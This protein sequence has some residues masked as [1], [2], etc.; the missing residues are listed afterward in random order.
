MQLPENSFRC[1]FLTFTSKTPPDPSGFSAVKSVFTFSS[2]FDIILSCINR[3]KEL[4]TLSTDFSTQIFSL[5]RSRFLRF[6]YFMEIPQSHFVKN[7]F[8][9]FSLHKSVIY[10]RNQIRFFL[11]GK[12]MLFLNIAPSSLSKKASRVPLQPS[13]P[14]CI[15]KKQRRRTACSVPAVF[16]SVCG[17]YYSSISLVA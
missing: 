5:C 3:Y 2:S 10:A 11:S 16:V 7:F 12:I 9:L 14:S 13:F 17:L 15:Y 6:Y 1:H 4:C 8:W